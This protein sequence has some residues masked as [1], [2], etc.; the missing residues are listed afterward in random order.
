MNINELPSRL[1][2]PTGVDS[3]AIQAPAGPGVSTQVNA[4]AGHQLL[5]LD[6]W[7]GASAT[8]RLLSGRGSL[9]APPAA[10]LDQLAHYILAPLD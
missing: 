1:L 9:N 5:G 10:Q 8:E 3:G 2:P 7:A 4:V 6:V